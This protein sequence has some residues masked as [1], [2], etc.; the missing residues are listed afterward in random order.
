[1]G[2]FHHSVHRELGDGRR[3]DVIPAW[4]YHYEVGVL[5]TDGSLEVLPWKDVKMKNEK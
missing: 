4:K 3:F 5:A 2:H 1:M